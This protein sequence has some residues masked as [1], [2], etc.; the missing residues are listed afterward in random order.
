MFRRRRWRLSRPDVFERAREI[1]TTITRGRYRLD[2]DEAEAEFRV[3]DETKEG[4]ALDELSSGTRVQV[5]LAVRIAFVEQQEQE[6]R[7]HFSSTRRS[8]TPTTE[9]RRGLSSQ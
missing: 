4:L 1:L 6:F 9:E 7:F 5:L 2:F 8:P 3:F